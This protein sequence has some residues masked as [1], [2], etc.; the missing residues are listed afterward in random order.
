MTK[1]ETSSVSKWRILRT[2]IRK[3]PI[4]GSF[5]GLIGNLQRFCVKT[6]QQLLLPKIKIYE[7]FVAL[8]P[9]SAGT[10]RQ[11]TDLTKNTIQKLFPELNRLRQSISDVTL[12]EV[13]SIEAFLSS[14]GYFESDADGL[15]SLFM[16]LGS[17]K[18]NPNNY[19]KLYAY[20]LS[21]IG[22]PKNILEIGLGSNNL[23]VVSNMGIYGRPGASIRAFRDYL[24]NTNIYGADIDRGSLF[25]EE[26]I[27]TCWVDQTAYNSLEMMFETFKVEFD[28][29]ID[30]GLHSP[31]AN[32]ST[33]TAALSRCR[34]GGFIVIED[35]AKSARDIW[36]VVQALLNNADIEA[37]ILS[38]TNADVFLVKV[39]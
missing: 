26:R 13:I 23:N 33:L 39:P 4:I 5:A 36:R 31:D 21:A 34:S 32:I 25:S 11:R 9:N 27:T 17:D 37:Q 6:T 14:K 18:A 29:V 28:L 35:V 30:D 1:K 10:P 24:P 16:D 19:Y 3:L 7:E 8:A 12:D 20:L 2:E 22:E 15:K 38:G